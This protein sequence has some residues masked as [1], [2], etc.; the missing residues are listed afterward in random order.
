MQ[1]RTAQQSGHLHHVLT[2]SFFHFEQST[3]LD[4]KVDDTGSNNANKL[5][6]CNGHQQ[7]DRYIFDIAVCAI[8]L[9]GWLIGA[10]TILYFRCHR[11]SKP[12]RIHKRSTDTPDK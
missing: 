7:I 11:W 9:T 6:C 3:P 5:M 2:H 1:H 4:I 8:F 12:G 10:D